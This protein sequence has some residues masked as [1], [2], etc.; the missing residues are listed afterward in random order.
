MCSL[1]DTKDLL[2]YLEALIPLVQGILVDPIPDV[3]STA[4]KGKSISKLSE[5]PLNQTL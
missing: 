5:A 3:R 2:P 1:A 4:A